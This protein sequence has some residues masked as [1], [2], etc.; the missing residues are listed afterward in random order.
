MRADY[1]SEADAISIVISDPDRPASGDEVHERAIVA[2]VDG[3]PVGFELLYPSLG[4]EEPLSEVA[5]KYSL[6][7]ETLEAVVRAALAAPDR[8]VE[9]SDRQL[10]S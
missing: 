10:A 3:R 9:V 6:D 5:R 7:R 4:I 1:D 8:L 2:V